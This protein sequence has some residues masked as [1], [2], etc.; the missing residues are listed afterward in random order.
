MSDVGR[1]K[2]RGASPFPSV[3]KS[4]DPFQPEMGEMD[5]EQDVEQFDNIYST[6][7]Q[8]PEPTE[9]ALI[10]EDN[11]NKQF[12]QRKKKK[13]EEDEEENKKKKKEEDPE[14]FVDLRV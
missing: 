13:K 12:R 7:V 3:R 9:Q 2:R 6:V 8:E 1:I 10:R 14:I 5:F 4:A 11:R